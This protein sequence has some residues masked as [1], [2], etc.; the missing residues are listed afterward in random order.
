VYYLSGATWTILPDSGSL[1]NSGD[2]SPHRLISLLMQ[3]ILERLEQAKS[4]S[5]QK[6]EEELEAL[7][8]RIVSMLTGLRESLDFDQGGEL[9]LNL[10]NLYT[11]MI[12]RVSSFYEE[13]MAVE[14]LN[15]VDNLMVGIKKSWDEID[16]QTKAA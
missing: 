15:E 11:Y 9:A 16:D 8:I 1:T 12:D 6:D 7:L 2:I 4:M 10:D 3:G 13:E 5:N 14:M